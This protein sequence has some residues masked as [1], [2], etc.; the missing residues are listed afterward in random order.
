[1][2]EFCIFPRFRELVLLFGSRS[3]ENEVGPPQMR[4]RKL[5]DDANDPID[6]WC[7]GFGRYVIV[8]F[9]ISFNHF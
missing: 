7:T 6:S 2:S 9:I 4:F 1:M 5:V 8:M 3:G